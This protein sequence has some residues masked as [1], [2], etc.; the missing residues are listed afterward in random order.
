M[1]FQPGGSV[2]F[3]AGVLWEV[4]VSM[5]IP[6]GFDAITLNQWLWFKYRCQESSPTEFQRLFEE[7]MKRHRPEFMQIKPYGNI[8]DRKADGL[9]RLDGTVFQVYSPDEL[10][11]ANVVKKIDEDLDGAVSEWGDGIKSWT[12]V[13]NVRRGL[14]PDIPI[15]LNKK[16]KQYPSI[17][18]G[19]LSNDGLWEILR[20]LSPQQRAEILGAPIGYEG[21]F[22]HSGNDSDL[23]SS[24]QNDDSWIVLIQDIINPIDIRAV[25]DALK[26]SS[27]FGAPI[28]LHPN[29]NSWDEAVIYQKTVVSDLF[30]KCRNS[31]PARFAVFS[32]AP[33]PLIA[34]LG[35]LLTYSVPIRYFKLHID[36]QSWRWPD[37]S[38]ESRFIVTGIPVE[39]IPSKCDVIIRVSLSDKISKLDTDEIIPDSPV[40]IDISVENPG[41]T[42]IRSLGQ[43]TEFARVFREV[44]TEIRRQVPDCQSIHL[45]MAVPAPIALVAGQ[46]INPRMNPPVRL[47]EYARNQKPRY[48]YAFSLE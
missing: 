15:I 40:Q 22:V 35:F 47:Y 34:Q 19:N 14:P 43:V 45:F 2:H 24:E 28:Y 39:L 44:L 38:I 37:E 7:I 21:Y 25:I 13:Y 46:Q 11:Q 17:A 4:G 27:I 31:F 6:S 3:G 20:E 32:I 48:Q 36:S 23:R 1:P 42:W 5:A 10:T 26:P 18:V 29:I 41:L 33:I 30:E 8:G 9:L 12:F 16:Q